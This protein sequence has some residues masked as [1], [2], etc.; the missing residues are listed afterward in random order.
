M[1]LGHGQ[2]AD[3]DTLID[4]LNERIK[5]HNTFNHE[6]E[7]LLK[8][9]QADGLKM[10][11]SNLS[12]QIDRDIVYMILYQIC[13]D[14]DLKDFLQTVTDMK[15]SN[16]TSFSKILKYTEALRLSGKYEEAKAT[17]CVFGNTGVGKHL[18]IFLFNFLLKLIILEREN[19]QLKR[20]QQNLELF[21]SII[22]HFKD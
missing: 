3:E 7:E 15:L 21:K 6:V 18:F 12:E 5:S 2:N 10:L 4:K 17:V 16:F 9:G 20:D 22:I 8:M 11:I 14:K 13:P 19:K 1:K